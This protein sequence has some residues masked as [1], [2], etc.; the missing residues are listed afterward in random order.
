MNPHRSHYYTTSTLARSTGLIRKALVFLSAA[1]A[2]A[3]VFA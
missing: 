2:L 3:L 1:L